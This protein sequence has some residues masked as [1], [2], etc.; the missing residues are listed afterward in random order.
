VAQRFQRCDK[1]EYQK[2]R[3]G[4]DF[5]SCQFQPTKIDPALAAE[6]EAFPNFLK[7]GKSHFARN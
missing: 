5:K 6:V 1:D 2:N 3:E 4:H 7:P